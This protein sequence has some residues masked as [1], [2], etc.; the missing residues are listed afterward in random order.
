M[1]DKDLIEK[2]K[3]KLIQDKSNLIFP[4][5]PKEEWIINNLLFFGKLRKNFF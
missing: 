2:V 1:F 3:L 4:D 5:K